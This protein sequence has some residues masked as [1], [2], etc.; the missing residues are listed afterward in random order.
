[1]PNAT[2]AMPST[3]LGFKPVLEVPGSID[4]LE[5]VAMDEARCDLRVIDGGT[6]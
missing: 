6:S 2:V 1:M 4:S 5:E 3:T